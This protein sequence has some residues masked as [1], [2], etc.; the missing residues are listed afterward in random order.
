LTNDR[1][2]PDGHIHIIPNDGY[3]EHYENPECW[4]E[5]ELTEYDEETETEVWTHREL[6]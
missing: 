2:F 4:C 3:R 5:P 1:V 6:Q